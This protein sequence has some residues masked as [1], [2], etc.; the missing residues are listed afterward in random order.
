METTKLPNASALASNIFQGGLKGIQSAIIGSA[1]FALVSSTAQIVENIWLT[2][3]QTLINE[4][5]VLDF[6]LLLV[7]YGVIGCIVSI[8][9][10]FVGGSILAY[11]YRHISSTKYHDQESNTKLGVLLGGLFGAGICLLIIM[12]DLKLSQIIHGGAFYE[13]PDYFR[14]AFFLVQVTIIAAFAGRWTEKQIKSRE[15]GPTPR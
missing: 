6:I 10:A 8:L 15:S 9:P 4:Y 7:L 3:V 11:R 13:G 1:I 5:R 2:G 14:Y 12:I